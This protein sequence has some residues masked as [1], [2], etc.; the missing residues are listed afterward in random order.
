MPG[1]SVAVMS[2][3]NLSK[4]SIISGVPR[5]PLYNNVAEMNEFRNDLKL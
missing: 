4:S 1:P 5:L 2:Y 3:L